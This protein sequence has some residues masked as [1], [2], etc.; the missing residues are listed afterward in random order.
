MLV[1][2]LS[3][4]AK[5]LF[6]TVCASFPN[7]FFHTCH[8]VKH[9]QYIYLFFFFPFGDL[10]LGQGSQGQQKV[11]T[12]GFIILRIALFLTDQNESWCDLQPSQA[13]Y[14]TLE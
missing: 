1:I 5:T 13:Y 14:A 6:W 9:Y 10:H 7:Y 4:K 12:V 2:G 8:A 11:K 3:C